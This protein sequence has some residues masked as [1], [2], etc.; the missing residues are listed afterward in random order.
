MQ[1]QFS[2]LIQLRDQLSDVNREIA[3]IRHVRGQLKSLKKRVESSLEEVAAEPLVTEMT[4]ITEEI[5]TIEKSLYQTES[6]SPQDPLNF[7]I[8]LNDKLA[9]VI[10]T[11]ATGD[12]PPTQQARAVGRELQKAIAVELNKLRQIWNESIPALND[13]IQSADIPRVELK[14]PKGEE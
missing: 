11:V 14:E 6:E 7:P 1:E 2:Y 10:N 8:R 3:Q 12:Y 13:K 9:G 4:S 5:T